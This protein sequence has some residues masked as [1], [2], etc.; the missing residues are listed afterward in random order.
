MEF[1]YTISEP[2][3]E[4]QSSQSGR[5]LSR[6][7]YTCNRRKIRCDKQEPC[8]PCSQAGK[9]CAYPPRR[10]RRAKH[11][12]M[13]DMASRISSLEKALA[14]ANS[15]DLSA[16][17]ISVSKNSSSSSSAQPV[18]LRGDDVLVE[19]G[20]SSQY[21]NEVMLS[22]VIEEERD[23]ES[24]LS[25]SHTGTPHQPATSPFNPAGILSSLSLL[26]E[27]HTF[28]PTQPL[29]VRLWNNYVENVDGCSGLIKLLHLPT[30]R[31]KVYSVIHDPASA[32]FHDL[33]FCFAIYF[34]SAVSFEDVEARLFLGLLALV[35]YLSGLRVHNR[36][37]GIWI[38]NGLTI[39]IA[40]SLG[41]HRDGLRLGLPPFQ[42][43]MRRRLWWHLLSRDSRSGE[44][45][46]LENTSG[47]L[48]GS[49]VSL[50][51]NVD[52]V[53][54]S[55]DMKELPKPK[56]SWTAMT[57][58]LINI[59]LAK[60]IHKLADIAATSSLSSPPTEDI[61]IKV[62]DDL[63]A[64]IEGYLQNCNP[65]IPQHRMTLLCSRFLVRKL[66]FTTRLQ[67]SFL[68][69]TMKSDEFATEENLVEALELLEPRLFNDDG[70]LKQFSWAR[71]AYPQYH[72]TMYVLWHLCVK[73]EGPSVDRAWRALDIHFSEVLC[74]KSTIGFGSKSA[75][76]TA[77]KAKAL[78]IR[79]KH[80][81]TNP[82]ENRANTEGSSAL[83]LH[84]GVSENN[85]LPSFLFGNIV[86]AD[87]LEFDI[88]KGEWLD[89]TTLPR[90]SQGD[91]P[92]ESFA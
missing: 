54:L 12:I 52:D 45:Y 46:G 59:E 7:C 41:L 76:L 73:P 65:V 27:P 69:R 13:A 77:L 88:D 4:Q 60:S 83:T 42:S 49:N 66:N 64:S 21:F 2:E 86:G 57:F 63:S 55:P 47:Q 32:S 23:I 70:L 82:R 35:I 79:A 30:D 8:T 68:R 50:P 1:I 11:T 20:S 53:D 44:D 14:K 62:I 19:K 71:R 72:I 24:V 22:R 39:R 89:W 78:S 17:G 58:S 81:G 91:S 84:E 80:R 9:P 36:G 18:R 6:S 87:S 16:L 5:P 61:R 92:A 56:N 85:G 67:W 90:G 37:K 43:E 75:V 26:Q 34:A 15:K 3:P 29:A 10:I 31:V 40:Q 33:A 25:T 74:D 48:L 28:H 51:L 38:L